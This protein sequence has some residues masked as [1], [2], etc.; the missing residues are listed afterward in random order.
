MAELYFGE[1]V[2]VPYMADWASPPTLKLEHRSQLSSASS[3]AESRGG[4]WHARRRRLRYLVTARNATD[5]GRIEETLRVAQEAK[6][7]AIPYWAALRQ[8]ESVG[9][10]NL[11]LNA[12]IPAA[13]GRGQVLWWLQL[14]SGDYGTVQVL[15]A[16]GR[17]LGIQAVPEGLGTGCYVAPLLLGSIESV[18]VTELH[19]SARSFRIEFIEAIGNAS[20]IA[21]SVSERIEVRVDPSGLWEDLAPERSA[22]GAMGCAL[23]MSGSC[24]EI[25]VH[26]SVAERVTVTTA[27]EGAYLQIAIEQPFDKWISSVGVSLSGHYE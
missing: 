22:V 12:A 1:H 26:G 2:V 23:T 6:K 27:G 18:A 13:I 20:G 10:Q 11:L 15:L 17:T 3:G 25:V 16:S 14:E 4:E 8:G 24:T 7:A 5:A 9:D 21:R 19:G